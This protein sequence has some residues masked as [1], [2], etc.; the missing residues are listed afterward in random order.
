MWNNLRARHYSVLILLAIVAL[1]TSAI[2]IDK[3]I[4]RESETAFTIESPFQNNPFIQ[5]F[6][7]ADA[8]CAVLPV[9][10]SNKKA[11]TQGAVVA[12]NAVPFSAA[13][14]TLSAD[15]V[16][17][18]NE[19]DNF[20]NFVEYSV[21]PGDSISN[22]AVLFGA[23]ADAIKRANRIDDRHS[24]MA[25]QT[26]RVP[27]PS[28]DMY[29]T[30]R[31][32]DSL[33]R[34]ASRF[35]VQLQDIIEANNLKSHRLMAEQRIRIPVADNKAEITLVKPEKSMV[36]V[37]RTLSMVRDNQT[38]MVPQQK[39]EMIKLEKVQTAAAPA[40]RPKIEFIEKDLLTAPPTI[41]MEAAVKPVAPAV[42]KAEAKADN[43]EVTYTV[44]KGDSLLKIAHRFNTTVAQLQNDNGLNGT[45]LK[46]GQEIRINPDKKLFRVVKA[47]NARPE[48]A[49]VKVV[50]HKIENGE[51]LSLVA[52]KYKTT[53]GAIVAENNM[54]NTVVMAGQTIK[55]PANQVRD[56][57]VTQGRSEVTRA[58]WKMP[59]RGRLSDK[60]GWRNHPVYRKRL[61][62]AGIDIAAPKG[63]PIAAAAN[64]KVIYAGRRSGYGNLVIVSHAS[65]MSTRYAHCSSILVKK[66]QTVRAG[67]L[68]ARVGATGV[69]TGNHLH[70][71]VRK[72]GKPQNPLTFLK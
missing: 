32:G 14:R 69:A 2:A 34:I 59:V 26:I 33:S 22:I 24:I 39:L 38:A 53:V 62:H 50:E 49:P 12:K 29:Y 25:G 40:A 13:S 15:F 48:A 70:F 51:S 72:N 9:K 8:S 44:S 11:S 19:G 27:M 68:L 56:F 47:E 16:A 23:E 61:F 37:G 67:Q 35:R 42:V 57:K 71:E 52:R 7:M 20:K 18:A 66:G 17:A 4:N 1:E 28:K 21:Q 46:V 36:E 5:S 6:R 45:F 58:S 63:A 30:V 65:G 64:G 3:F 60:Y 10:L 54:S 41:T 55:V 43:R 31:K